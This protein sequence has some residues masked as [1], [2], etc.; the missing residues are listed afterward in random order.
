[1][2]NYSI[3]DL[4]QITGIKAHT[5]RMWEKRYN[6]LIPKRTGSNI[7]FYTDEDLKK[8][9]NVSLLNKHGI[10][11]SKIANLKEEQLNEKVF[12]ISRQESD[13]KCQIEGLVV[14]MI[15][16]NEARF[17]KIITNATINMGFEETIYRI[18]Y[19]FFEKVGVLWMT[20]AINPAQ[21]HFISNLIKQKL[22]VAIDNLSAD[23]SSKKKKFILFL[24]EWEL[25]EIGLMISHYLVKKQGLST[26]FLGQ[27]VPF[28]DLLSVAKVVEPDYLITSFTSSNTKQ[29][30]Q[31]Y[32]KKLSEAFN[33]K[34]IFVSGAYFNS[35]NI[36]TP[37]NIIHVPDI[38]L[39][40][41]QII[42]IS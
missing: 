38:H 42:R 39:F 18:I 27:A 17:E 35:F 7:R 32:I 24:P 14:A 23:Q 8:L 9:L 28:K 25:H 36:K 3:K 10:K 33:G 6:L 20:G 15:D 26:I 21:E 11:I 41:E 40:K 34:K 31:E 2:A 4:E 19:P 16:L 29:T 30:I 37:E 13:F 5:I 22:M 12:Q 1:M